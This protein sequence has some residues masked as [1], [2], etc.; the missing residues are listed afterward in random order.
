MLTEERKQNQERLKS[1]E[2]INQSFQNKINQ[3]KHL[4][5]LL[6]EWLPDFIEQTYHLTGA[7]V[8]KLDFNKKHVEEGN[9][10]PG[11]ENDTENPKVITYIGSSMSHKG[12]MIGNTLPIGKGIS[13]DVF[14]DK[15]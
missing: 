1:I 3:T 14:E 11:A 9:F 7:Y 5:D 13:Y 8:G 2:Q 15:T 12:L 10:E 6:H 4:Q